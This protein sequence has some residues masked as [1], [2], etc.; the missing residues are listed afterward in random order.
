MMGVVRKC[1]RCRGYDGTRSACADFNSDETE[2]VPTPLEPPA[3]HLATQRNVANELGSKQSIFA[4]RGS[5]RGIHPLIFRGSESTP[6]PTASLVTYLRAELDELLELAKQRHSLQETYDA[7]ALHELVAPPPI[8]WDPATLAACDAAYHRWVAPGD[9]AR[10]P[11]QE[12]GLPPWI[13]LEYLVHRHGVLAHGSA[14]DGIEVFEPR[15]AHDNLADGDAPKIHA[16]SSG[17]TALF[18]AIIDRRRLLEIPCVPA[19]GT[20]QAPREVEGETRD[21]FWF[22]VDFRALPYRPWRNGTVYLLPR[23]SFRDEHRGMQWTSPAPVHP[24]ARI[25]VTPDDFPL[26]H[27]V[28]GLDFA[29]DHRRAN[30]GI[31]GFPWRGDPAVYPDPRYRPPPP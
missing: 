30:A 29:E 4:R 31:P 5:R 23:D 17:V 26:L 22:V 20:I 11:R 8:P 24:L 12:L 2:Y 6:A 18:Y 13:F 3:P 19:F 15:A 1:D 25:A 7:L 10:V 27:H 21:G 9:N 16:A 28:Y 14:D